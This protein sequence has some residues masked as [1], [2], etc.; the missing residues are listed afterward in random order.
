MSLFKN[1]TNLF[2]TLIFRIYHYLLLPLRY[3]VK[4]IGG[5]RI[6]EKISPGEGVLFLSTHPSHL[7]PSIV[8]FELWKLGYKVDVWTLDFVYKNPYTRLAARNPKTVTMMKVP[9]ITERRSEKDPKRLRKLI[10]RTVDCLEEG[11]NIL[12]FPS[13]SQKHLAYEQ[14]NGKSAVEKIMK[15][16]PGTNIV[17][18]RMTGLWGSRFSKAMG[19]KDRS[20]IQA[21]QWLRFVWN[22]VKIILLNLIFFIPKRKITI[23]FYSPG[24]DFPRQGTRQEMNAYI[25]SYFNRG[26]G[27]F[28]EPLQRVPDYFWKAKYP[29]HEYN[30]KNYKFDLD[31]VPEEIKNDVI[32]I[33]ACKARMDPDL[34]T[35]DM[36]VDRDLCLDSLEITELLV[37]LEH[38]YGLP[39]YVPKNITTVGHLMALTTG[40]PIEYTPLKGE[41]NVVQVEPAFVVHAWQVCSAFISGFFGF[42]FTNQ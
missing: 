5:E 29:N 12:F 1:L 40:I 6:K 2:T 20:N 26:Y 42:H 4:V 41:F 10:R 11:E 38:K 21:N 32:Q 35:Y 13:G 30:L 15:M 23:E 19:K 24:Q 34:I 16:H 27:E 22:I 31:L 25:E 33:L 8:G 39:P 17:L 37:E 14:I 9:N 3:K 36:L 28:G 18:I 7:D